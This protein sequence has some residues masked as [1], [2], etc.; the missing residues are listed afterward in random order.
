MNKATKLFKV[1]HAIEP[2]FGDFDAERVRWPG[3]FEAVAWVEARNIDDV[4]RITNHIDS[5]W[6]ENPEVK[7]LLTP[8]DRTRSTS[9]GDV[10]LDFA[11]GK[12]YA[13]AGVGWKQI[14]DVNDLGEPVPAPKKGGTLWL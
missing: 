8:V 14:G 13:V 12:L 10:V 3:N 5:N 4:F 7:R 9:V 11:T 1:Y 2:G 6:T